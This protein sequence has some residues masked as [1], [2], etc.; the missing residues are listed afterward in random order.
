[1]RFPMKMEN[2]LANIADP[3]RLKAVQ[4]AALLDT[5]AEVP[6]DRVVRLAATALQAPAAMLS[7]I[8]DHRQ[9]CK[10]VYGMSEPVASRREIP[11][12]HSFCKH[13][14]ATGKTLSVADAR[15]HPELKDNPAIHELGAL[16]Y[17]GV[18]LITSEGHVLGSLAVVDSSPRGWTGA[19]AQIMED[20]AASVMAAIDHRRMARQLEQAHAQLLRVRNQFSQFME[21]T[22]AAAYIKDDQGRLVWLNNTA[23][24]MMGPS[25]AGWVGRTGHEIWPKETAD[26]LC[27]ADAAA[28]AS[29]DGQER[30]EVVPLPDGSQSHWY[31]F[32][33]PLPQEDGRVFLAGI[34]INISDIRNAE[35]ARRRTLQLLEAILQTVNDDIIAVD[36][37]GRTICINAAARDRTGH[38]GPIEESLNRTFRMRTLEGGDELDMPRSALSQ[39]LKGRDVEQQFILERLRDGKRFIIHAKAHPLRGEGGEIAVAVVSGRDVTL[40]W[41]AAQA[42]AR[43]ESRFRLAAEA[44]SGFV[45][46]Y[47]VQRNQVLR[48][49]GIAQVLGYAPEEAGATSDWWFSQIHPDD[50]Q[51]VSQAFAAAQADPRRLRSEME[52]RMRRSDGRYVWLVD[53]C[54]LSRDEQGRLLRVVGQNMDVTQRVEAEA[55]LRQAKEAADA[56]NLAKSQFLAQMSHEIR[57]PIS[58]ILGF[59]DLLRKSDVPAADREEYLQTIRRNAEHLLSLITDI[60][61][62]SKIEADAMT[63]E[64]V[65]TDL[66]RLLEQV[67]AMMRPRAAD[68]GL[69]LALDF[70]ADLPRRALVDPTRLKQILIN[71]VG[72]A[73][74]FTRRGRVDIKA[75]L[76][77]GNAA[78][79]EIAVIDTGIGLTAGQLSKL[80]KPFTQADQSHARQFGGTGLGLAISRRLARLMDGDIHARGEPDR[81]SQFILHLPFVSADSPIA[82]RA[83]PT[84]A[85][86]LLVEESPDLQRLYQAFLAHAGFGVSVVEDGAAAL[87]QISSSAQPRIDLILMDCQ[88]PALDGC[89]AAALIRQGGFAGPM[90]ALSTH[91]AEMEKQRCLRLG[92]SHFIA[93]HE[94]PEKL[95]E[96]VRRALGR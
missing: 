60:L 59:A 52:Y 68:K 24:R 29:L 21:K 79:L 6:F 91:P 10:A 41:E 76:L 46:D 62:L 72:N 28:Y 13:V 39:A 17:L 95:V 67:A 38:D 77:P 64:R 81:G 65:P 31:T 8:D 57:T 63:L 56:A 92:F 48:S 71:L 14:V 85:Q 80:F 75:R 61:D 45:Y 23:L 78:A 11:L 40:A 70:S 37:R 5:P 54:I 4:A 94:S 19:Q 35:G 74:K 15:R 51:R 89:A 32:R 83:G 26:A 25:A 88:G 2:Q 33:Y 1:M 47:D 12:S 9:F 16:A 90:I 58:A 7:L 66:P 86:V 27:A 73:V 18:P 50:Q 20:L 93:K 42:L 44:M 69:A 43:S 34:S 96:A 22:P 30:E 87:R 84:A 82:D 53:R 49:S 55:A 36:A 3:E